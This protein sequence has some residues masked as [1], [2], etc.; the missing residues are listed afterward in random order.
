MNI[1]NDRSTYVAPYKVVLFDALDAF[2]YADVME[3]MEQIN[4]IEDL[5][6][7]C[8][9]AD[10]VFVIKNYKWESLKSMNEVDDGYDVRVY[11]QNMSCVHAAHI[12]YE[13]N[14]IGSNY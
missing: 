7:A 1:N 9:Y 5:G 11:D 14:W 12:T 10:A 4:E 2:Y 13:K 6:K 8:A 3:K